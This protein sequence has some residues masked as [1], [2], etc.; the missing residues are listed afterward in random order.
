[1]L[2]HV[3]EFPSFPRLNNQFSSVAQSCP[4]IYDPMDYSMPGFPVHHILPELIQTHV[5]WVG[6]AL[7]C[8]YRPHC[9]Y[10]FI[11]QWTLSLLPLFHYTEWCCYEHGCTNTVWDLVFSTFKYIPRSEIAVSLVILCLIFQEITMPFSVAAAPFS[12]PTSS[13][14]TKVWIPHP[15]QPLLFSDI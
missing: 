10:T 3:L 2:R 15:H 14:C 6:D 9:V 13:K 1:M 11:H 4:T 7:H 5:H 12:I 8:I